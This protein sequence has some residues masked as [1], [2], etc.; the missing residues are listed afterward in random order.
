MAS[1]ASVLLPF[2]KSEEHRKAGNALSH[3]II[4]EKWCPH[5]DSNRGPT[6]YKDVG[7]NCNRVDNSALF[8]VAILRYKDVTRFAGCS[9]V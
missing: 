6:D 3:C 7:E 5:T 8:A 9:D 1:S 2:L 4:M